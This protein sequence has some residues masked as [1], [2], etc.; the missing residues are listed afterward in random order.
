MNEN[1]SHR[2]WANID[3]AALD[4]NLGKIRT[5]LPRGIRYIAV[6]K[7]DAYGH[8]LA[9]MV[10]RLMQAGVDC[11][12]V[13]NVYEA[14]AV[15][16]LGSGWPIL[17]LGPTLPEEEVRLIQDDLIATLSTHEELLRFERMGQRFQ[18]KIR[19]HL[20]VD[21]GMG[22]LGVW[23]EQASELWQAIR[24]SQWVEAEG[25]Y[26]HFSSAD[27]DPEFTQQQRKRFIDLL[28]ALKVPPHLVI[29][30]DN[31]SG[32]QTLSADHPLN[33]VRIGLLQFGHQ[34]APSNFFAKLGVEPVLSL[35]TRV[36]IIKRLPAGT[37]ISYAQ[38]HRL[39][40]DTTIAILTAG[41][42]DGIPTSASNR[43]SVLIHETRCPIIGRI[44]M[45][46]T[47][48]DVSHIPVPA[49]GDTATLIGNQGKS[50]ITV[51]EF[52]IWADSI[53]WEVFCS[54]TK[55][56]VRLYSNSRFS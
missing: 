14:R 49:V 34:P 3:L 39:N 10:S 19:I 11:F 12:A 6:V 23:Y 27:C 43:G 54:I 32:L 7:A 8:G 5:A 18:H 31:S 46:Q 51:E 33:A 9:P 1:V 17:I 24:N 44:T 4:R 2:S 45:D 55:R 52:S 42:G 47:I 38:T 22:R 15:R 16:E 28:A 25:I 30:A 13:A 35:H 29:H 20:K 53:P 48:V 26:T 40:A 56:V 41:Y 37:P 50:R 36:G 21:T